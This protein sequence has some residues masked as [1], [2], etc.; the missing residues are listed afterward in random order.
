[1]VTTTSDDRLVISVSEFEEVAAGAHA[2]D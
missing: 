1:M 2:G